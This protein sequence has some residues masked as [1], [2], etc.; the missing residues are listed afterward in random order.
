VVERKV[1][2]PLNFAPVPLLFVL[3]T[4]IGLSRQAIQKYRPMPSLEAFAGGESELKRKKWVK[5]GDLSLMKRTANCLHR[6]RR[7]A[8]EPPENPMTLENARK[9]LAKLIKRAFAELSAR[10]V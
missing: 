5:S 4:A 6:H 2:G 10:D 7:G 8:F 3:R 1:G 9:M